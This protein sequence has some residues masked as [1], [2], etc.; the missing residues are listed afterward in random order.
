MAANDKENK[1]NS[2]ESVSTKNPETKSPVSKLTEIIGELIQDPSFK[3]R[4]KRT[5]ERHVSYYVKS[6]KKYSAQNDKNN[7]K[8]ET[9][10]TGA[11]IASI[12]GSLLGLNMTAEKYANEFKLQQI[13]EEID[14][15][16]DN[17]IKTPITMD[18]LNEYKT[19]FDNLCKLFPGKKDSCNNI[20]N[21]FVATY[22]FDYL[23]TIV[24][25]GAV[26]E[27]LEYLGVDNLETG[28]NNWFPY[29]LYLRQIIKEA[30][31]ED[32][33]YADFDKAALGW[34]LVE[35]IRTI[36]KNDELF[37]NSKNVILTGAP[38]TGKT[39]LAHKLAER[40]TGD[41]NAN[42]KMVQFHPSYDY[43]DFVEGLRPEKNGNQINFVH[44]DGVF[45]AF[46]ANALKNGFE[47]D[48]NGNYKKNQEG[49]LIPCKTQPKYVFIID[50]INRGEMSKIF[51][52]LF[53][54][55]DPGYRGLVGKIQTQYA[56]MQE[57]PNEFDLALE[58]KSYGH[59]FVP[60]NV[61]IIGTMNDIDRSVESMDFAM[62]RRFTFVEITAEDRQNM[63]DE[64][65][66]A[67]ELKM[68][69]NN[70]NSAI[71]KIPGL[72]SAYHIGPAYFKKIENY[73][74]LKTPK[75]KLNA[76]WDN[77]LK[78]V[79]YEYL[80]GNPEADKYIETIK[81]A[82]DKNAED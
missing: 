69:M 45:K 53:F 81:K 28:T 33:P 14:S 58:E 65:E 43:S 56:N 68:R 30:C 74:D 20:T 48:G 50:E 13:K 4:L 67:E 38:G 1:V 70:V 72:N 19:Y 44:K 10:L 60:E 11:G 76:L 12:R 6:L 77:H 25:P 15:F 63:L 39:F 62:R 66:N 27:V 73:S 5:E 61:Y 7:K 8:L 78:G 55:I 34:E 21:R 24:N 79:I 57:K 22:L 42:I 52:E 35:Y 36:K 23:T 41:K 71:E 31:T 82:Y 46:C 37:K 49:N 51:G 80:R 16:V 9:I 2:L 59:F 29:S 75:Q 47:N 17:K 18:V 3:E 54:S 40:L 26:R 64:L 32:K